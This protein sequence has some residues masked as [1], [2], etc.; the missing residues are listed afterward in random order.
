MPRPQLTNPV[1]ALQHHRPV[2]SNHPLIS[3]TR[4]ISR[5]PALTT[6]QPQPRRIGSPAS[7][8]RR[9]QAHQHDHLHPIAVTCRSTYRAATAFREPNT[10]ERNRC[11]PYADHRTHTRETKPRSVRTKIAATI[12]FVPFLNGRN[13]PTSLIQI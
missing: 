2:R 3:P 9:T 8:S 7:P 11:N 4:N 1:H 10:R 12:T 6:T 5:Q 13:V